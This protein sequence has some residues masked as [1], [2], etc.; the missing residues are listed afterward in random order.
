MRAAVVQQYGPPEVAHM[1]EIPRPQPRA[2][3]VLV[4][5]H[6]AAVTAADARIRGASFPPGF[7]VLSRLALGIRRPRRQVLGSA[8][9]GEVVQAVDGGP[10]V[11]EQVCGMSGARF[12]A[13]AEYIAVPNDRVVRTPATVSHEQA[14]GMLFG[15]TTALFF[16]RDKARV[17]PGMTVLVIGASGAVGTNAV[18]LA[19][20]LGATVT[21]ATSTPNLDLVSSLGADT[22]D[23]T[24]TSATELDRHY[25]V[26]LDATGTLSPAAGRRLV[27]PGG[28]LALVAA[29]LW[30]ILG[31]VGRA[32][33]GAAPERAA[34]FTYLLDL[35]DQGALTAVIDQDLDLDEIATA[36]ARVDSGRK[37]GNIIVRP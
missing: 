25:D 8:F 34:D 13:H 14:A 26:V 24:R 16:L 29:S 31:S 19:R 20:H 23:Y 37:V 9:S 21:G 3:E 11:G 27:A 17:G 28:T 4:R 30:Q 33:A 1:R 22:I 35:M 36:H 2:G 7:G 5:V 32:T 18:Q 15:G 6:A 12:G 10:S